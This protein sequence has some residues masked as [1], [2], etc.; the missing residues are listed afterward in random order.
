MKL[1]DLELAALLHLTKQWYPGSVS[2][3]GGKEWD[4]L[5]EADTLIEEELVTRSILGAKQ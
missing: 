3:P 4:R 1:T 5:R 2:N